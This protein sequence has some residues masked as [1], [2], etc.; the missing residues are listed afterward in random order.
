MNP[1]SIVMLNS[2][3][4]LGPVAKTNADDLELEPVNLSK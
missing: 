3:V 4:E 1:L 2:L